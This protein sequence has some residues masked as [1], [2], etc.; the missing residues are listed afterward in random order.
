MAIQE[1]D[2]KSKG[3]ASHLHLMP[4]KREVVSPQGNRGRRY[5]TEP[6][7]SFQ[8]DWGFVNVDAG[9]TTFRAACFAMICHHC[10]NSYIEFFPNAKQENLFIGMIHAF[11]HLGIPHYVLT[12]NMKSVVNG[13]DADGHPLWN[14]EYAAF[15]EAVGF[16][17]K[18]CKPRHLFTKGAVERLVRFVKESFVTGRS[19]G[20][21]TDLNMEALRWCEKQNNDYH[22]AS[23]CVP[24]R[25]HARHWLNYRL[26]LTN[27]RNGN[28][29]PFSSIITYPLMECYT[30]FPTS[31]SNARWMYG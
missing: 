10:G 14:H 4:A 9:N 26:P 24:A 3:I 30:P 28:K 7:E 5:R 18:L 19:F 31:S 22:K 25:E 12:D 6:G 23:D 8:M 17:T 1:A 16:Q 13:R 29:P 15:M 27:W 2:L 20:N 21:I 11:E